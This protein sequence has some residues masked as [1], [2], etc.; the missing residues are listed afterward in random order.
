M[1]YDVV[2]AKYLGGYRVRLRFRDGAEGEID[3]EARLWGPV[4]EPLKDVEFFRKFRV[5]PESP[6]LVWPSGAD[7]DRYAR[8]VG[9][10]GFNPQHGLSAAA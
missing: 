6:T 5:D 3:L 1:D 7:I 9:I 4:L 10:P 8:R 2:D